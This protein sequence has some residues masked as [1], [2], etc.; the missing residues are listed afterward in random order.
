MQQKSSFL[1]QNRTFANSN[2]YAVF[3]H[4]IAVSLNCK[5]RLSHQKAVDGE[6]KGVDESS[7]SVPFARVPGTSKAVTVEILA[8]EFNLLMYW[9]DL[10][11]VVK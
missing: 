7:V 4:F 10:T 5:L 2:N 6:R 1:R 3:E 8:S 9:F 11:H